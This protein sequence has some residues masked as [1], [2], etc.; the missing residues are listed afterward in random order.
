MI[1]L[2]LAASLAL[3]SGDQVQFDPDRAQASAQE[4][5]ILNAT[6]VC[7]RGQ[8]RRD[9][10]SGERSRARLIEAAASGCESLFVDFETKHG[11]TAEKARA[12]MRRVAAK[13]LEVELQQAR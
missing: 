6:V 13:A 5:I 8:I 9:L 12:V 2:L 10:Y 4:D 3:Q 11:K 7:L 1:A